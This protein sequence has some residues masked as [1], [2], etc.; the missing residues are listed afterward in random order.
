MNEPF[1]VC[2]K[3]GYVKCKLCHGGGV[4]SGKACENCEGTVG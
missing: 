3:K 2:D 1:I 4:R